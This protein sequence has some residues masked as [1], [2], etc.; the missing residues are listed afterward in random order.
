MNG[1]LVTC[2]MNK[3]ERAYKEFIAKTTC[4]VVPGP[5]TCIFPVIKFAAQLEK[6]IGQMKNKKKFVKIDEHKSILLFSNHTGMMPSS[7]FTLLR[8]L[9]LGFY[10]VLRIIPLDLITK[11]DEEKI[12]TFIKNRNFTGSFK[13]MYEGRICDPETRERMFKLILPHIPGKVSLDNPDHIVIVQAF[14]SYVGL[15]VVSNDLKNFNFFIS[16]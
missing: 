12:I 5:E 1:F 7:M 3:E 10:S 14:K 2:L 4:L 11:F 13:I 8:S 9:Q 15:S 6:E 16:H